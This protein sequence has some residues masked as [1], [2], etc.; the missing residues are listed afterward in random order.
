VVVV[1]AVAG[2]ATASGGGGNSA[3]PTQCIS[4]SD[5]SLSGV[6]G[7]VTPTVNTI[8]LQ[9]SMREEAAFCTAY[10]VSLVSATCANPIGTG[11]SGVDQYQCSILIKDEG[12]T[13][14]H[15]V[16]TLHQDIGAWFQSGTATSDK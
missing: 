8:N 11:V 15:V 16:V 6:T 13:Y 9:E 3:G 4:I 10:A 5:R 12:I 7:T 1:A 2:I 14:P